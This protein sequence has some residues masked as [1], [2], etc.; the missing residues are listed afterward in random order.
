VVAEVLEAVEVAAEAL[1]NDL[2]ANQN[3]QEQ[4]AAQ[5]DDALKAVASKLSQAADA[6]DAADS[7]GDPEAFA[8][9]AVEVLKE[10]ELVLDATTA[11]AL[12]DDNQRD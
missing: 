1:D 8:N 2:T 10:T 11:E 9:A 5:A 4:I 7:D 3:A 6:A 12:Q